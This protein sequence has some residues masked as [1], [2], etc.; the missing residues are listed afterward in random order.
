MDTDEKGY[1]LGILTIVLLS[2]SVLSAV[3][4]I[5]AAIAGFLWVLAFILCIRVDYWVMYWTCVVFELL[6]TI[7]VLY[8]GYKN[9]REEEN[10]ED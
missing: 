6:A 5:S 9:R 1:H 10:Y 7:A 4:V 3:G 2:I 8:I